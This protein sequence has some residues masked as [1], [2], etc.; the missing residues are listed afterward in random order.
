MTKTEDAIMKEN[1]LEICDMC[2]GT[3][4]KPDNPNRYCLKCHGA[5]IMNHF[6]ICFDVD[7]PYINENQRKE[8][9]EMILNNI[10]KIYKA[11]GMLQ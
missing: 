3:G 10:I 8:Q 2:G 9:K 6:T 5:K 4:I 11:L 1:R 7:V